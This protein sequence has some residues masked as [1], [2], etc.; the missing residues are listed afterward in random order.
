MPG[1][2]RQAAVWICVGWFSTCA[3]F[4]PGSNV[5]PL[6]Y[7][8]TPAIAAA[9]LNTKLIPLSGRKGSEVF[10]AE[11]PASIPGFFFYQDQ[12]WLEFRGGRLTGWTNDWRRKGG[13]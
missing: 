12:L 5:R 2:W 1:Q 11:R 3:Y 4:D 10:Y 6:E 8:M 9:A 7:G 13:W